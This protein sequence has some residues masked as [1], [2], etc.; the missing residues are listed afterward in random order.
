MKLKNISLIIN[1]K[2]KK[3]HEN[4]IDLLK[5]NQKNPIKKKMKNL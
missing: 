5:L 2:N 1:G 4:I 3:I